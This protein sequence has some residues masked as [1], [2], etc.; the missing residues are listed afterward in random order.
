MDIHPSG[1]SNFCFTNLKARSTKVLFLGTPTAK[2]RLSLCRAPPLMMP[3]GQSSLNNFTGGYDR[4]RLNKW[5]PNPQLCNGLTWFNPCLVDSFLAWRSQIILVEFPSLMQAWAPPDALRRIPPPK[6]K[7]QKGFILIIYETR[8]FLGYLKGPEVFKTKLSRKWRKYSISCYRSSRR[9]P[10]WLPAGW[11]AAWH[12][13]HNLANHS[14]WRTWRSKLHLEKSHTAHLHL[15]IHR[16]RKY[17][18]GFKS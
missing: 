10:T 17:N 3:K 13:S 4:R 9:F 11:M 5:K 12:R 14:K 1:W 7:S 16:F 6:V 18:S 15:E 2:R 8:W